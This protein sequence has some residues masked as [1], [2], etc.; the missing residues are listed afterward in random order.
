MKRPKHRR[1]RGMLTSL[2][3]YPKG[4]THKNDSLWRK[5][6]LWAGGTVLVAVLGVAVVGL[7]V[8]MFKPDL[9]V[10]TKEGN[11]EVLDVESPAGSFP[12]EE[13]AVAAAV[14]SIEGRWIRVPLRA[15]NRSG[16]EKHKTL[17]VRYTLSP[18]VGVLKIE[19]WN[20]VKG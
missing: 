17:H 7:F 6:G 14:I 20:L 1:T 19:S 2:V 12:A 5:I 11:F 15:D 18:R 16:V 3:K 13:Q 9:A 10:V 4:P 8:M